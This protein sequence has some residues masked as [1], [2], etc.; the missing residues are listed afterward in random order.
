[1]TKSLRTAKMGLTLNKRSP[2]QEAGVKTATCIIS[3]A[4]SGTPED[5]SMNCTELLLPQERTEFRRLLNR[6]IT[7]V[8]L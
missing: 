6:A 4:H 3:V 1:M 5:C 7:L 8:A 2:E